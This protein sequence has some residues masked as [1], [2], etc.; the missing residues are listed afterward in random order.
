M[1]TTIQVPVTPELKAKLAEQ[2]RQSGLSL[3]A[4][5][6]QMIIKGAGNVSPA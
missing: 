4:Y 6:R 2:A 5:I 1:N 3:A